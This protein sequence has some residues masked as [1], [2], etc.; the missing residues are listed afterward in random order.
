MQG[1]MLMRHSRHAA[2]CYW[3]LQW[4]VKDLVPLAPAWVQPW[5]SLPVDTTFVV[6]FFVIDQLL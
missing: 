3:P 2:G 1:R 5:T 4:V 6:A